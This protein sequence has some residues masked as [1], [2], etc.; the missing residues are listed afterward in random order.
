MIPVSFADEELPGVLQAV[1][2]KQKAD[3]HRTPADF[4]SAIVFAVSKN[5]L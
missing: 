3:R 4:S 2:K 5:G 1:P